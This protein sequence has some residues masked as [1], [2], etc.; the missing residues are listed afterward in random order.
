MEKVIPMYSKLSLAELFINMNRTQNDI[1][2]EL[3]KH[4]VK[5]NKRQKILQSFIVAMSLIIMTMSLGF[6]LAIHKIKSEP[7]TVYLQGYDRT[8]DINDLPLAPLEELK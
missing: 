5:I 4:I 7:T 1:N 8:V 6:T 2:N 3:K